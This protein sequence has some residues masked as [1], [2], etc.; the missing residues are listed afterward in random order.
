[1]VCRGC[2][3]VD[4]K[5]WDDV[6]GCDESHCGRPSIGVDADDASSSGLSGTLSRLP[7]ESRGSGHCDG[8]WMFRWRGEQ[9]GRTSNIGHQPGTSKQVGERHGINF[10]EW[11][12]NRYIC[13]EC[14]SGDMDI[15][16]LMQEQACRA[17]T[18]ASMEEECLHTR[19]VYHLK[20]RLNVYRDRLHESWS[21]ICL[22]NPQTAS[23]TR[24]PCLDR[25]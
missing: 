1:V 14:C 19:R 6:Q 10:A 22:Q 21:I 2:S 16:S 5:W 4:S 25:P 8:S 7:G 9:Q 17:L 11:A 15:T 23:P 12:L 13:F 3:G 20:D 18:C 24:N